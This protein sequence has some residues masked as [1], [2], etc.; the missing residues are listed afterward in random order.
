MDKQTNTQQSIIES[1]SHGSEIGVY[2]KAV[3]IKQSDKNLQDTTNFNTII[4]QVIHITLNALPT[5]G[6]FS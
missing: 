5:C 4:T 6:S 1:S 2:S 3:H